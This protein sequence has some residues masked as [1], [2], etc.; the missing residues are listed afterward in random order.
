MFEVD[1]TGA[2]PGFRGARRRDRVRA[3]G[4]WAWVLE[5]S[6]PAHLP[7]RSRYLGMLQ[8]SKPDRVIACRSDFGNSITNRPICTLHI[9]VRTFARE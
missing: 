3:W 9:G 6:G 8:A 1:C 5:A 4:R 2:D 7:G